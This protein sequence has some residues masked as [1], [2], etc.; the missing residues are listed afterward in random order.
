MNTFISKTCEHPKELAEW[1]D[2]MASPEG[3]FTW[4]F[5]KEGVHYQMENGLVKLT[6]EGKEVNQRNCEEQ[7]DRILKVN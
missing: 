3:M 2:Y 6:E 7:K 5:G 4:K 1:M